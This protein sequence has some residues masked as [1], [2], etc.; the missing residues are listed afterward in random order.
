MSDTHAET[1]MWIDGMK[2]RADAAEKRLSSS[3]PEHRAEAD[4]KL[5]DFRKGLSGHEGRE[6]VDHDQRSALEKLADDLEAAVDRAF[7]RR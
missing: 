1:A 6:T 2:R 3:E 5:S 7:A 4:G